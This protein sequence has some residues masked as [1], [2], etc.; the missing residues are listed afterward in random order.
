MLTAYDAT[1]QQSSDTVCI[2]ASQL[3]KA[4]V[5]IEECKIIKEDLSLT[6]ER[7]GVANA[8]LELKDSAISSLKEK[9]GRLELLVSNADERIKNLQR[10]G[11]N[12]E[13]ALDLQ[14]K[15]LRRQRLSKWIAGALGLAA[16]IL[17]SK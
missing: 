15:A 9:S 17:I 13:K 16:G 2:P 11:Q 6:L 3:K 4:V 1:S 5:K 14:T 12:L 10:Q 7:L 8:R